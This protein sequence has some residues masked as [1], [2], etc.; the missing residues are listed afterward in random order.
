MLTEAI[1]KNYDKLNDSD[2]QSL[3]IIMQH[4]QRIG[5]MTIEELA[6]KCS[7]SK[8]TISRLAQKLGFSGYSEF[9]NCLKWENKNQI[10]GEDY[11][12]RQAL[13]QD[14]TLTVQQM[15]NSSSLLKAASEIH[16]CQNVVV[17]GTGQAQRHCAKELQRLL[18]QVNKY[19]S[20]VEATDEFRM[21]A[22]NLGPDDCVI[23]LSLSGNADKIKET[24]QLL[25]L[26]NVKMISITNLQSNFLASMCNY[27]LYA[28]SSP[29]KLADNLYHNSFISFL[30]VIEYIFLAYLEIV[31]NA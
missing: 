14:F 26:K 19:V 20:C 13:K 11:N 18:M 29:L 21:L 16:K 27:N 25:R 4:T 28:V 23:I 10:P 15:E 3:E 9:K 6:N 2:L 30:T 1:N 7:T 31:R 12:Y 8:S 24:L 22:K 5:N 17:Y